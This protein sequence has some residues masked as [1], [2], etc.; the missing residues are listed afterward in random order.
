MKYYELTP[1]EQAELSP[2]DLA[3]Y[4]RAMSLCEEE[5]A[6]GPGGGWADGHKLLQTLGWTIRSIDEGHRVFIRLEKPKK[7]GSTS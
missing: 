4:K 1:E 3:T 2:S 6:G 7:R 5:S